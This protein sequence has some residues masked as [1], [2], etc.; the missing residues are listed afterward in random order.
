MEYRAEVQSP[1]VIKDG[2]DYA[3]I[4]DIKSRKHVKIDLY[5]LI[6]NEI[7]KSHRK[8]YQALIVGYLRERENENDIPCIPFVLKT[9][10][11]EFF[12]L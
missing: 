12:A 5:K 7:L 3:H 2:N 4:L 6:P 1:F 8:Y 10:I 9:L 11:L